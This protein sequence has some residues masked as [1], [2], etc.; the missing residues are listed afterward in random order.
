MVLLGG[1]S[2][3]IG[4]Y[5]P[6]GDAAAGELAMQF[7]KDLL[8]GEPLG[9]ALRKARR[10]IQGGRDWANYQHFGNPSYR[11]RQRQT[12]AKRSGSLLSIAPIAPAG[13]AAACPRS[14]H[15]RQRGGS[16]TSRLALP[17]EEDHQT[18]KRCCQAATTPRPGRN[19]RWTKE[20]CARLRSTITALRRPGK[21]PSLP[22]RAS[23]TSTTSRSPIRRASPT[24]ASPSRTTRAGGSALTSRANLVAVISNGTAV[25]GLGNIGPLASKPVME[26]KGCLFKKFAGIDVFDIEIDATDP[27]RIV[28]VVAALEPTFGGINLEDIKA[29]ECFIVE[30]R[31]RE[32]MKIPV[33]HDDQHG[34]AI[35]VSAAIL[36]GL[37]LVGKDIAKVK[38]AVSGAGAA[39]LACLDLLVR[40]GC[41]ARTSPSA[42]SRAWSTRAA[43]RRWTPRRRAT[44][45]I[46]RR[47][48]WPRSCRVPTS[49][50]ASRPAAC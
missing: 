47:A 6:V 38:V 1:I 13:P 49:S 24:R 30:R 44:P 25:L 41:G 34:T 18:C 15:A 37:Q 36:N 3:F 23:P 33:F 42:T 31:L 17:A 14:P 22:P 19:D 35:I 7:Y 28:E 40:W 32:R 4:T 8:D 2:N 21:S 48:R 26:G 9:L 20:H 39:A 12:V 45:G 5:W 46:P 50:S 11:L 29:P 27:D 43:R 16:G 10:Q